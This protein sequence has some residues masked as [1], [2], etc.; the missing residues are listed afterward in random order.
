MVLGYM[1]RFV[2]PKGLDTLV[3][4]VAQLVHT[5][6]EMDIKVLM[7]GSGSEEERLRLSITEARLQH[8]FVFTGAVPHR[9]AGEYM[10][11]MDVFVLPSRTTPSWKEQFGRVVIEALA[12][13]VPVIGSNSGQIPHL[14]RDTRGGLIFAEGNAAHLAEKLLALIEH[15]EQRTQLGTAGAE[16]VRGRYTYDAVAGQ[17]HGVF[18]EALASRQGVPR[19]PAV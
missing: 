14:I 4:A 6:P 16:A 8:R 15:P 13:G 10:N 7:V 12:C 9:D 18:R 19:A 2:K 1:G 5:K 11:C 3:E 17:L